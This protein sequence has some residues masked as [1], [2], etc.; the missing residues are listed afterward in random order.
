M[1]ERVSS[2]EDRAL[3]SDRKKNNTVKS[4]RIRLVVGFQR[5][6]HVVN[7]GGGGRERINPPG[8][9]KYFPKKKTD[10]RERKEIAA[11]KRRAW[12]QRRR[13]RRL[14]L[15]LRTSPLRADSVQPTASAAEERQRCTAMGTREERHRTKKLRSA[16]AGRR[17]R[18][19]PWAREERRRGPS[20]LLERPGPP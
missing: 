10:W 8:E 12:R 1:G 5:Q 13:R 17:G 19:P 18:A 2:R 16:A 20:S 14:L 9:H 15:L 3:S 7:A 11:G 4:Q 6:G